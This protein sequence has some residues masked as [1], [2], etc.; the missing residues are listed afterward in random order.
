MFTLQELQ[1]IRAAL[2]GITIKGAD[3]KFLAQLQ[4]KAEQLLI[5]ANK[6]KEE[7]DQKTKK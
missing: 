1:I 4:I 5:E 3:A 2:D 7:V 6:P